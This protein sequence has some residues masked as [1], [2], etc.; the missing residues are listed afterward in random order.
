VLLRLLEQ[1]VE[2][3]TGLADVWGIELEDDR[4]MKLHDEPDVTATR[5][6]RRAAGP[7][8]M[9]SLTNALLFFP[10]RKILQTPADAKLEFADVAFAAADGERLHGW[11]VPARAPS[12]GHVLLCHGNAGN[13]GDRVAHLELLSAVG[14]DALAFDYR[15][16]GHSSGRPSEQGTYLDAR[17]ARDALL[18]RDGVD[19][20]RVLYL[21]ESLGGAV[22]L[23]LAL[24]L[25]PAAVI[26]QSTFTSVR[27]MARLHYRLLPPALVPD[28]YPSLRLIPRLQ[29]PL[30][31]LHGARDEIVPLIHAQAL[32]EAAST[33][34]RLH[35]FPGVGHN[36]LITRAGTAW[37]Q[38]IAAWTRDLPHPGATG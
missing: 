11:W 30:L 34:K 15:G 9:R 26:L 21:G 27:D 5:A 3:L 8:V 23:A 28:A 24:E 6:R 29:A 16:Y 22:A 20:S 19:S 38:A 25:P 18:S 14:F 1:L 4:G 36:D 2:P 17:A 13:I 37:A 31:I 35:V 32:L 33:T 7:T 12:I 10:S